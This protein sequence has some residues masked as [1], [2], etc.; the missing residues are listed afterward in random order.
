MTRKRRM[1][2]KPEA[3]THEA[4][5]DGG[6]WLQAYRYWSDVASSQGNTMTYAKETCKKL[7]EMAERQ[8]E[9][10]GHPKL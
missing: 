5:P 7:V 2:E 1:P 4:P 10:E 3:E 9:Q 6:M 8:L